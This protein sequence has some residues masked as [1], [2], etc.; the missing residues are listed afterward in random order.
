[1]KGE[2]RANKHIYAIYIVMLG[3]SIFFLFRL[4]V[5]KKQINLQGEEIDSLVK[6]ESDEGVLINSLFRAGKGDEEIINNPR[7]RSARL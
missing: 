7:A 4:D 2:V 1:M 6:M 3:I 5:Q